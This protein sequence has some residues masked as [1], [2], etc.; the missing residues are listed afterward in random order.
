MDIFSQNKLL[1]RVV[2]ILI[3]INLLSLSYVLLHNRRPPQQV[4]NKQEK[5]NGVRI[6]RKQ[7]Q[8][9][10]D[11]AIEFIRIRNDF[12]KKEEELS[13]LV[14][15]RRDSMNLEMFNEVTD[16]IRLQKLA[17]Q[18]ATDEYQLELYRIEQ[19]QKLKSICTREQLTNFRNL[20]RDIRD[21]FQPRRKKE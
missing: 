13:S 7:L 20:V 10:E 3:I 12:S 6:L 1:I 21:F 11:Q 9:T 14:K 19:S 16:T 17:K 18:L 4:Q 2:I 8:L 15:A 5:E